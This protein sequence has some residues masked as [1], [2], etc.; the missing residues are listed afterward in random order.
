[1]NWRK[2]AM[3]WMDK[4]IEIRDKPPLCNHNREPVA[5]RLMGYCPDMAKKTAVIHFK[6]PTCQKWK[7]ALISETEVNWQ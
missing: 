5:M 3:D 6:C 7:T 1:M 2:E 4:M